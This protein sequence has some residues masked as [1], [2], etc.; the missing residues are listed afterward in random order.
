MK[1]WKRASGVLKDRTSILKASLT[2]RSTLRNPNLETAVIRATT[3]DESSVDY[4][5]TQHVFTWVRISDDC[6]YRVLWVLF[7]RMKRTHNWAVALK[8]LMLLHGVFCCKVPGIQEI[9]ELPSDLLLNVREKRIKYGKT[10]DVN[11]FIQAYYAFLDQ[12]SSFI[13][14]HSQE[15]IKRAVVSSGDE[16]NREEKQKS[17]MQDLIWLQKLQGLI[18]T[19]LRIRPK[20]S[21][22]IN[23]LVLEAM[24]CVM[25]EIYDIYSRISIGIGTV[26]MTVYSAGKNEAVIVL[27][28]L[29]KAKV[30]SEQVSLFFEFCRDI[31]VG[32]TS[33]CPKME[34]IP[35]EVIQELKDII[36]GD[37]EQPRS[38]NFPEEE[39]KSVIVVTNHKLNKTH[40]H[41]SNLSLKT[42]ITDEWEVFEEQQ[43][44][45]PR[46]ASSPPA[47]NNARPDPLTLPD[48]ISL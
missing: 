13:S 43:K 4:R 7:R 39:V 37:S 36:S 35:E 19:L 42:V 6:L 15:R 24:D 33:E 26:L 32:N 8:G 28:I 1:L 21:R 41:N 22:T 47:K 12:K 40:D 38:K 31:G 14:L 5:S 30:Q 48:L 18:D 10:S 25:I 27:P 9:G 16:T 3:H 17:M 45:N 44:S 20:S 29:Q 2:P 46:L 23:V 34:N 11:T